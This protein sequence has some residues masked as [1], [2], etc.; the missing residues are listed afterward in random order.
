MAGWRRRTGQ[1]D[2]PGFLLAVEDARD[3]RFRARFTS[4]CRVEP[5]LN[6]ALADPVNA[7]E[8]DVEGFHDPAI[9][10]A[11]AAVGDVG[12]EQDAP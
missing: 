3:R 5:L 12:L 7:G 8:T 9:A 4:K 6:Q 10:P 1:G 2:Q 11:L